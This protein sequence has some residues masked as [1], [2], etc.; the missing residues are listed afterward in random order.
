MSRR[1][2]RAHA[3]TLRLKRFLWIDFAAGATVGALVLSLS[4]WLEA[5]YAIPRPF[6]LSM[7][8]AGLLY[9][10]LAL[11]LAWGSAPSPALVAILGTANL[12]WAA[13]CVL[14]AWILL[15]SA[16][17]LGLAHLAVE[18]AFVSWLGVNELRHRGGTDAVAASRGAS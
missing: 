5:I 2:V 18:A 6:I 1:V 16:S 15:S 9:A 12:L 7:G 11:A 17:W 3:P 14:V 13:L 8:A 4:L 10:A